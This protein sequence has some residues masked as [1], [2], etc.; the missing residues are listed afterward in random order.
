MPTAT[1]SSHLLSCFVNGSAVELRIPEDDEL[2]PLPLERQDLEQITGIG[3]RTAARLHELGII[4]FRQIAED[5]PLSFARRGARSWPELEAVLG[6]A[7]QKDPAQRFASMA[8]LASALDA[9]PVPTATPAVPSALDLK[10]LLHALH[11]EATLFQEGLQEAPTGS[12]ANGMAGF[13][14]ALYRIACQ[15]DDPELLAHADL[16]S[17][18]A[19]AEACPEAFSQ[20]ELDPVLEREGRTSPFHCWPGVFCVQAKVSAAL[21]DPIGAQ[22]AVEAFLERIRDPGGSLDLLF[23]RPG[24]LH[25]HT[26]V[27]GTS[28]ADEA[29]RS[30]AEPLFSDI[31]AELQSLPPI[32]ESD[33]F[34]LLGVAHGWAGVLWSLLRWCRASGRELPEEVPRRLDQLAELAE[35]S[36]NG[37]RWR[38]RLGGPDGSNMAD[39]MSGWCNGTAGQT[40]L[41]LEAYRQTDEPRFETLAVG[42]ARH[43]LDDPSPFGDLCCGL[44]GRA[45]A[46]LVLHQATGERQWLDSALELARRAFRHLPTNATRE[47]GLLKGPEGLACLLADLERPEFAS[48]PGFETL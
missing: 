33:D 11:P 35:H 32:R 20:D 14:Y 44:T 25:G 27:L 37:V 18:R 36:G 42:A 13:A 5:P 15:R 28:P 17:T 22:E 4:S 2:D 30:F 21:G 38:R 9:I 48:F 12:I 16:W 3:P 41:W 19:V 24:V 46:P 40:F 10:P 6:R 1:E 29:V 8:D 47:H 45:Y 39:Y 26:E 23:G 31:L 43:T 34:P 7:L